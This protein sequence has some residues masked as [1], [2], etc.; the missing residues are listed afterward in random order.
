M[1]HH[2]KHKQVQTY[3]L[4]SALFISIVGAGCNSGDDSPSQP[5]K[6]TYSG[7]VSAP[8]GA[9][10]QFKD[11]TFGSRL[12][13][14]V[15]GSELQAAITGMTGVADAAVELIQIDDVGAQVGD[16]I[17]ST[18]TD[19]SG[20]YSLTT[21]A[22]PSN[23]LVL[24]VSSSSATVR[25]FASSS[26][27]DISPVSEYLV[28]KV[29]TTVAS[30][31]S[32]SL[33]NFNT[34]EL[35]LL[36]D[37]LN[38]LSLFLAPASVADTLI[39]IDSAATTAGLPSEISVYSPDGLMLTGYWNYQEYVG[40]NS[41][42]EPTGG[43]WDETTFYVSQSGNTLTISVGGSE[44]DTVRLSGYSIVDIDLDSF[45]EQGGTL[46]ETAMSLTVEPN[47][48]TIN[49]E[50]QWSWTNGSDSCSGKFTVVASKI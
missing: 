20:A 45:P 42:D 23:D 29:L 11:K 19:S 8:G 46:T 43:L 21:T 10:A 33:A 34:T 41:C 2:F 31:S 48:L 16:I 4:M 12:F 35:G 13:A 38:D 3:L 26:S 50:I 17:A 22:S 9:I 40:V 49:G 47:G 14:A 44:I 18:T 5:S 32:I 37:F 1:S 27:I 24:R 36:M 39:S 30:S 6:T 7:S 15:F 25:A 28:Q